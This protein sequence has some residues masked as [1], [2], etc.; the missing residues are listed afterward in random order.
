MADIS[1]TAANVAASTAGTAVK[2]SEYNF[3]ATI[4]QGQA[5][6]LDS[7]NTWQKLDLNAAATG[8]GITDLRGIALNSGASGQP[9]TVVVY[10]E[11]FTPGGTL[12]NG[13]VVYGSNTPGGITQADIPT[14][15][16]YPVSLGIAKSTTKMVL[17]I[18]ASGAVI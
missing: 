12:T 14:T 3:G 18:T 11:D 13:L 2:R 4:T 10:D 17:K 9:A 8:N 7:S 5:V 16:A 6:Y 15:G 1:I